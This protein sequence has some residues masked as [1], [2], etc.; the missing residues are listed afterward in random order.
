MSFLSDL[1]GRKP[2]VPELPTVDLG[3]EQKKAVSENLAIAPEA[4]KLATFSQEQ[5]TKMMEMAIPGFSGMRSQISG[6]ISALLRGEIPL[7]VSQEVKR[8]GAGRAL[9]GGFG[10][11]GAASNLVARD[12]GLTSLGLTREGLNSAESWMREME[13]LYSPSQ[14]LFTGMFISP[15]QQF[16][17]TTQERNMQFQRNWLQNQI[18]AAPDPTTRGLYDTTMEIVSDVLG[19]YSGGGSH[20]SYQ[21]NYGGMNYGGGGGGNGIAW[22]AGNWSAGGNPTTNTPYDWGGSKPVNAGDNPY[23]W[24]I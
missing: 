3:A 13:Q 2:V 16:A 14:A 15:A 1:Y 24:G 4:A 7:D 20:Q 10:G 6:N 17:A 9:T 21:P 8:Q 19:A 23:N 18:A 5:I 11:T 12:L 22:G